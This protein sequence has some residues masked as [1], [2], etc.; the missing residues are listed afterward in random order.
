MDMRFAL[1]YDDVLLVPKRSQVYSRKE[2]S[3][4]TQ[5]TKNFRLGNPL[6]TANMD[7][8]TEHKMAIAMA[9][10]GGFSFLHRF[11][12][13]PY[14]VDMVRRVKRSESYV[15]EQPYSISASKTVK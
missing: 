13:I 14:K 8:V 7:T 5:L 6:T 11:C 10:T 2:I 3:V 4:G 9:R 15:I 12:D 1:S